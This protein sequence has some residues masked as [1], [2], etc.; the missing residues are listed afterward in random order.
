MK[1]SEAIYL[2]GNITKLANLLKITKSA[3]SQWSDDIPELRALQLEKLVNDKSEN[4]SIKA[5]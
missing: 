2:A 5:K 1:K 3:V 4:Y